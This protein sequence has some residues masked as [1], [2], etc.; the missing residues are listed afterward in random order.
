M[1]SFL[2]AGWTIER[3]RTLSG[4]AGAALLT[5]D[6]LV[7]AEDAGQ[8]DYTT[9]RPDTILGFHDLCLVQDDGEWFMGRLD[10]DGSVICW[11]SYGSDLHEAIRGL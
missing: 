10:N 1:N 3:V 4:D 6:R 5:L 2:P 7:V 9:L 8:G 11:A